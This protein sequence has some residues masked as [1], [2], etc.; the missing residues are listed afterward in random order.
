MNTLV[1]LCCG[2][3]CQAGLALGTRCCSGL[4]PPSPEVLQGTGVGPGG[5]QCS[6]LCEKELLRFLQG[7]LCCW[8]PAGSA[9][10]LWALGEGLW[11]CG[12]NLPCSQSP[13]RQPLCLWSSLGLQRAS[14]GPSLS[15][16]LPLSHFCLDIKA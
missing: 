16:H 6:W 13:P 3:H 14:A 1:L 9:L 7:L 2:T 4:S 10:A 15:Q 5:S 11:V 8:N 12:R